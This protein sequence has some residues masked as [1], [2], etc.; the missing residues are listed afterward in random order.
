MAMDQK[1]AFADRLNRIKSGQQFEHADLVG[2]QTQVAYKKIHGD[3]GRKPKRTPVE[4]L[5][6]LVAFLSGVSAVLLGRL[7]YFHLSKISGLPE[8]FYDLQGRGM[9]LFALVLAGILIVIFGLSTRTRLQSLALGCALMHFGEAAAASTAPQLWAEMFSPEYVA[10]V[11][12]AVA[13][14]DTAV[15]G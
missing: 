11:S 2:Y 9:A 6:V 7:A 3:K 12:G 13:G 5:M 4:K 8:A 1:A 10:E 14:A 15:H